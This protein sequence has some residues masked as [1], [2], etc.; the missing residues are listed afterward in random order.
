MSIH[1]SLYSL[2]QRLWYCDRPFIF[3]KLE[4]TFLVLKVSILVLKVS[5][6][7]HILRGSAREFLQKAAW[8]VGLGLE[9]WCSYQHPHANFSSRGYS[10]FL[11]TIGSP[12]LWCT[13]MHED[14]SF[15]H[16]KMNKSNKRREVGLGAPWPLYVKH[17]TLYFF[18]VINAVWLSTCFYPTVGLA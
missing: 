10:V 1:I 15:T 7:T 13:Y 16:I 5:I 12:C 17:L 11:A 6:V 3:A 2:V 4:I 8:G 18:G 14:K 9:W